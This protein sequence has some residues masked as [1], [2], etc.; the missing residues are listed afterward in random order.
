MP[1]TKCPCCG[2][3]LDD[4][5]PVRALS[6]APLR[7]MQ[8]RIIDVL[9]KTYPRGLSAVAIASRVYAS[10]PNGGPMSADNAVSVHL[11]AARPILSR[12]GWTVGAAGE[13]GN[14]RLQR[15]Q[16]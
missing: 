11:H 3:E 1:N 9:S 16:G 14:I 12:Y 10:D 15:V 7:P 2:K 8:R 6:H 4:A 13:Q 5:L